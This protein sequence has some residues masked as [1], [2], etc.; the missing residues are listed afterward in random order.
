MSRVR[1]DSKQIHNSL[2][3]SSDRACA[4]DP[5]IERKVS[6]NVKRVKFTLILSTNFNN[7]VCKDRYV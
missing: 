2:S 3:K 1:V 7:N 4:R 5:H 6:H